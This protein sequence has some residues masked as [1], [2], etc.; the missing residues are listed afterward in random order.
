MAGQERMGYDDEV[1]AIQMASGIDT[2]F[3]PESWPQPT[4]SLAEWKASLRQR[5]YYQS[6]QSV[7]R[8]PLPGPESESSQ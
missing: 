5:I 8:A 4:P 2:G 6:I 1:E 7:E 3:R